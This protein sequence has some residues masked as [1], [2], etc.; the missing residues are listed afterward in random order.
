MNTS[1]VELIIHVS[2]SPGIEGRYLARVEKDRDGTRMS[3]FGDSAA[4]ALARIAVGLA[5]V[6]VERAPEPSSHYEKALDAFMK[7]YVNEDRFDQ[8]RAA[9]N[10]EMTLNAQAAK[11]LDSFADLGTSIKGV[12]VSGDTVNEADAEDTLELLEFAPA[13]RNQW[14][15]SLDEFE[16]Y[17]IFRN[18]GPYEAHFTSS[19]APTDNWTSYGAHDLGAAIEKCSRHYHER[20]ER[21]ADV[22]GL[23]FELSG[24][25]EWMAAAPTGALYQIAKRCT[26]FFLKLPDGS[27]FLYG[28]FDAA[29]AGANRHS[30]KGES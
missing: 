10:F 18:G 21:Y 24:E 28:T 6:D 23:G 8:E 12:V 20:E 1:D 26:G 5:S 19:V 15:C 9:D 25:N 2:K 13:G 4:D 11:L 16:H 30:A 17:F 7:D 29:V 3:C 14:T 27:E 22:G